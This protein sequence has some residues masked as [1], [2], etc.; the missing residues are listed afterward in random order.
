MNDE[1]PRDGRSPSRG[2]LRPTRPITLILA[3]VVTAALAWL[4]IRR[5]FGDLPNVTWLAGGRRVLRITLVICDLDRGARG[6]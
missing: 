6:A 4:G 5:Y 1:G 3:A 2:G